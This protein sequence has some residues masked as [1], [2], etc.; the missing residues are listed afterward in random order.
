[1]FLISNAVQEEGR[2]LEDVR[3]EGNPTEPRTDISLVNL[4]SY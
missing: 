2:S 4:S 1:M 3:R